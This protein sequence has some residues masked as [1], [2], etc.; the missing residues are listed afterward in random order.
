MRLVRQDVTSYW[1]RSPLAMQ[2]AQACSAFAKL[3]L[4]ATG[5][6]RALRSE[7]TMNES[8]SVVMLGATGAVGSEALKTLLAM[9]EISRITLLGRREISTIDLALDAPHQNAF[10]ARVKQHVVDVADPKTYARFLP[11]HDAAIC[12]LGVGQ[13]SKMSKEEFVRIDRDYVVAFAHACKAAGV[14]HFELLNSVGADA[15]SASFYL[16]T[17]GELQ[18]ALVAMRFERLSLFQPSMILTPN[19]RYGFSQ[20]ITL[21]TWPT[22]SKA[23][24]GPLKRL[25][26]VRVETLGAAIARNVATKGRG[27]EALQW[28]RFEA[29]VS[30]AGER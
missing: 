27:V 29:L 1:S 14:R 2:F 12:T 17:K 10:S 8:L 24:F 19:N 9:E 20:A 7:E 21:A 23:L 28:D 16:R 30:S 25:R 6:W 22:L 13:P 18:D 15:K 11:N 5:R 3:L 4:S 26:G